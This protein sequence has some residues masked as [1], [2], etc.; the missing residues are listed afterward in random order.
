MLCGC[1]SFT[2]HGGKIYTNLFKYFV[3]KKNNTTSVMMMRKMRP[4][5]LRQVRFYD[6]SNF[7]VF[8]RGLVRAKEMQYWISTSL[9]RVLVIHTCM[10]KIYRL[11]ASIKRSQKLCRRER[12]ALKIPFIFYCHYESFLTSTDWIAALKCKKKNACKLLQKWK[13]GMSS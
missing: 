13:M 6:I 9:Y 1:D 4:E 2:S 5:E 12:N 10:Q 3:N 11:S 7:I 8:L